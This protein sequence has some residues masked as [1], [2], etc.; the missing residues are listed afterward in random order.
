MRRRLTV[1]EAR[2]IEEVLDMMRDVGEVDG[3]R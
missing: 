1:R 2:D 3:T